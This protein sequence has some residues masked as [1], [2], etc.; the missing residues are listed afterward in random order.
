[1][2]KLM[3]RDFDDREFFEAMKRKAALPEHPWYEA[4]LQWLRRV[5][6]LYVMALAMKFSPEDALMLALRRVDEG[7]LDELWRHLEDE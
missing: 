2:A 3:D 1:M 4:D 7:A 6:Y 5:H